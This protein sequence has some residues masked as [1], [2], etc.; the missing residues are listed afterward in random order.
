MQRRRR[1]P[2]VAL[3]RGTMPAIPAAGKSVLMFS[4]SG[5]PD[6]ARVFDFIR[7]SAAYGNLGA[8]IGAGFSKAVLDDSLSSVVLTW[9]E[10][11]DEASVRM[12]V[13]LASIAKNG[14]GFPEI[15][16]AICLKHSESNDCEYLVSLSLLKN[17]VA[18]LTG[19]CP[20][21]CPSGTYQAYL[22][23]LDPAWIVTTNYDLV[24]ESLLPDRAVPLGPNDALSAP[25]GKVPVYH[26]HGLCTRPEEIII[27]QED[28]I[29]LFRP[30]EYRQIKL[31]LTIRES[32]TLILGY[33]LGDVNVLTALDWSRNVF[34]GAQANYPH[35]V[36]QVLR[37]DNPRGMPYWDKNGLLIL[38][39]DSL[40][41]FFEEL[42][43]TPV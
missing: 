17:E 35:A 31:A 2:D 6:K 7:Q 39:S 18:A 1:N 34:K 22:E 15:A 24:I 9:S 30:S 14:Q 3:S 38:E 4:L 37:K 10:L 25:R 12:G 32:T 11:L 33:G 41:V 20:D 42:R 16:S 19:C 26:L 21:L 36:I 28:Y 27:A 40:T 23:Y 29:A 8:F 43:G 13:E 5:E